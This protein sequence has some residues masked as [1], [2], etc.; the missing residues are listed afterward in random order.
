M[1]LNG[2][3][4]EDGGFFWWESGEGFRRGERESGWSNV[5]IIFGGGTVEECAFGRC[6]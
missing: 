6:A 5:M 2:A 4:D 3:V 1:S